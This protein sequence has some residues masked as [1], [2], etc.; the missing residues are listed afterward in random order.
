MR[1]GQNDRSGDVGSRVQIK[2]AGNP[3]SFGKRKKD[4]KNRKGNKMNGRHD[5]LDMTLI[6][7]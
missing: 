7:S 6:K 1:F 5:F 4:G 3:L 2:D